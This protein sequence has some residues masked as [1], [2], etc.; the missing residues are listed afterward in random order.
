FLSITAHYIDS[1]WNLKDVLVDFVYLAGSHLGE[2][3]AQ[4]FMES[5]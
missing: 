4:V 5:L 3:I 2:N 1:D